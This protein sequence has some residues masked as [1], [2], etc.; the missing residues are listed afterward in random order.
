MIEFD[1]RGFVLIHVLITSAVAA[2]IAAGLLRMVLMSSSAV[3][4]AVKGA[5]NLKEAEAMLQR[6]ITYWNKSNVVCSSDAEHFPCATPSATPPGTCSCA[7]PSG[8]ALPRVVVTGGG[9]PPCVVTVIS[10]DP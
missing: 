2:L 3:D 6:A 10:S 9:A 8:S 7:C 1:R 5:R 4:R